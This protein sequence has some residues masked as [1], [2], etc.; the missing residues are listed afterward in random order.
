MK[1][2]QIF[3]F[4]CGFIS[5]SSIANP[6]ELPPNANDSV[7]LFDSVVTAAIGDSICDIISTAKTVN[8]EILGFKDSS[9]VAVENKQ[10]TKEQIAIL[11]FLLDNPVNVASNDTTFGRFMPNIS[12]RFISKRKEIYVELDFGLRKW[13][14]KDVNGQVL[15]EFDLKSPEFL[16]FARTVFPND[17]FINLMLNQQ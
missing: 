10:L 4:V 6:P 9:F 17:E 5:C 12:F 1:K 14:V 8:A 15:K 7:P 11:D 2:L 3:L 13:K 16:R